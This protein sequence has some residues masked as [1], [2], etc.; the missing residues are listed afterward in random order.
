MILQAQ[1]RVGRIDGHSV[2]T[3][4]NPTS[5]SEWKGDKKTAAEY[6]ELD[7]KAARERERE[8]ERFFHLKMATGNK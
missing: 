8:T 1:I 3:D 4:P 6:Y 2:Q 7:N 5:K